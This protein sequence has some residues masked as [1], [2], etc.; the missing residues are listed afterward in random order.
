VKPVTV[1]PHGVADIV[2]A[3]SLASDRPGIVDIDAL[4]GL[5]DVAPLPMW[6]A[7]SGS[8]MIVRANAATRRAYGWNDA[9]LALMTV[10][11]LQDTGP[12]S[13]AHRHRRRDGSVLHVDVITTPVSVG[14][15]AMQLSI[16][17][18]N[19]DQVRTDEQRDLILRELIDEH[20]LLR[21][22]IADRLHDGPAQALTAV[23]LRLG[24]LRRAAAPD[25]QTKLAEIERLVSDALVAVR[26]EMNDHRKPDDVAPDLAGAINNLLVRC[27]LTE[28]FT[29]RAV[30]R[31]P[32]PS[33]VRLLYRVAE[34]IFAAVQPG[35][36]VDGIR[37]ILIEIDAETARM[38]LP[39]GHD[40]GV[41]NHVWKVIEV[42]HG[43]IERLADAASS[44]VITVPVAS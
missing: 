39:I 20:E 28:R 42:I 25:V 1:G 32:S 13:N 12:G 43:S 10:A 35:P 2:H 19:S 18:D 22:G 7:D 3:V 38:T 33:V 16:V 11:D 26:A 4:G 15:I 14:G 31:T 23:S 21:N 30:G 24:L 41:D 5:F 36:P 44:I 34:G 9:E 40:A 27:N 29:V 37:E 6:L 17:R 8:S